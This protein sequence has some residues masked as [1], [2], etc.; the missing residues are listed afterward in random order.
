[1]ALCSRWHCE[2]GEGGTNQ[3]QRSTW[4]VCS[5]FRLSSMALRIYPGSLEKMRLPSAKPLTANLVAKKTLSSC[6]QRIYA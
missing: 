4:S 5:L 1:M 2:R 6:Q 3:Y